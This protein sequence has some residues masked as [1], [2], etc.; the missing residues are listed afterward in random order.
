MVTPRYLSS[1]ETAILLSISV[2][3]LQK[4]RSEAIGIPYIKLGNS[5]SSLIRYDIDDIN[6]Y[7]K[8]KKMKVM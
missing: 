1:K 3:L 8:S 5:T 7:L 2:D 4:W 6:N